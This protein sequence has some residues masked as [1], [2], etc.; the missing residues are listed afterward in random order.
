VN[1]R[2]NTEGVRSLKYK[3]EKSKKGREKL[4]KAPASPEIKGPWCNSRG[5]GVRHGRVRQPRVVLPVRY[6]ESAS[7]E[8]TEFRS[9]TKKK[10]PGRRGR[11]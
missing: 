7:G 6:W 11:S 4:A 9:S 2:E 8:S 3:E 5:D 10:K 1:K